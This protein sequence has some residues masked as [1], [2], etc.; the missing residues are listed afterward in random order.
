MFP[1]WPSGRVIALKPNCDAI[2]RLERHLSLNPDAAVTAVASSSRVLAKRRA[3]HQLDPGDPLDVRRYSDSV[4]AVDHRPAHTIRRRHVFDAIGL[5]KPAA[6]HTADEGRVLQKYANGANTVVELGVA[7]GG[8]AYELRQVLD[9]N[10]TLYLVAPFIPGVLGISLARV[11]ARRLLAQSNNGDVVWIRKVSAE[12]V[13][14][15]TDSIDFLFIDADHDLARV[16]E[17]WNAWSAHVRPGGHIALHDAMTFAG[18]WTTT[19]S[20]P[21][22]FARSLIE[23]DDGWRHVASADSVAVFQRS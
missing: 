18:G 13:Q 11:I 22:I 3:D 14:G 17:D 23:A 4:A 21:V 19:D 15:W 12:A 5:R 9:P 6:Q 16:E 8:S 1:T 10:G 7:E 2:D 20:G